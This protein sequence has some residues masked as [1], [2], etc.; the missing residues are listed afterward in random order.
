MLLACTNCHRQYDVG[1]YP[2][3]SL[4]R[5]L[6][7]R[8]NAVPEPRARQVEML[9][10]SNCGGRLGDGAKVC[11]YCSAEVRLADRGLGP[12]C[13]ECFAT[14]LADARFCCSC[15]VRLEAEVVI[16]A[17]SERPCPRCK[18]ALTECEA[19]EVRYVECSRCGGLWLDE[20]LFERIAREKDRGLVPAI[21]G[22]LPSPAG[23]GA[24]HREEVRYLPCPV[25]GQIMNRRNFAACSGVILDWC[26]GHGWWFD[27]Q[28]LERVLAFLEQGGMDRSRRLEHERRL[29]ELRREK[30]RASSPWELPPLTPR[31]RPNLLENLLEGL[32]GFL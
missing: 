1:A 32:I 27:E 4:V 30:A 6:C 15:G 11:E 26:R 9:H 18:Q 24:G 8:R 14:T 7:G 23:L 22:V 21:Q 19:K 5:C 28:E 10:C 25:C 12:A 20:P 2:P 29:G 17:L 13:P 16:R 31:S 3:G